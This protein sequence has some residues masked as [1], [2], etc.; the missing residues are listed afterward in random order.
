MTSAYNP[1]LQVVG[2]EATRAGDPER[3]PQI[4]LNASEAQLRLLS[5]GELIYVQGPRRRELAVV[6]VDDTIP[7]G[8]VVA[9][10]IAGLAVSEI[11]RLIKLDLDRDRAPRGDYA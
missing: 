6:A 9:R 5:D 7:R 3:G 8:G 1:P 11:V 2:F 10:D 4:R